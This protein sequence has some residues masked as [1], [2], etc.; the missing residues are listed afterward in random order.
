[1]HLSSTPWIR[2]VSWQWRR[3]GTVIPAAR[4]EAP[5]SSST[6][7]D[8]CE[9]SS[10]EAVF[11]AGRPRMSE[12]EIGFTGRR[13][14][15]PPSAPRASTG[16]VSSSMEIGCSTCIGTASTSTREGVSSEL[17]IKSD[18]SMRNAFPAQTGHDREEGLLH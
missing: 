7:R 4:R 9:G 3:R 17:P 8:T 12:E 16:R 11:T 5:R 10:F 1:M 14:P 18:L 13:R 15:A 6:R 2:R